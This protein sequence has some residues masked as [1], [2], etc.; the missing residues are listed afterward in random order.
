M[1]SLL[2]SNYSLLIFSI[3]GFI[4][5]GYTLKMKS[6]VRDEG[7]EFVLIK[8]LNGIAIILLSLIFLYYFFKNI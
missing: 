6:S 8:Y 5:G 1:D 2:N 7:G 3:I 4:V